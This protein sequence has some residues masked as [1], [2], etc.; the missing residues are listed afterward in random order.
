MKLAEKIGWHLSSAV[1]LL[2]L[3]KIE[4]GRRRGW[5]RMRW[6]NGITDSMDLSLS[7]LAIWR[8]TGRPGVLQSIGSQRVGHDWVTELSWAVG[9]LIATDGSPKIQ[10]TQVRSHR[11]SFKSVWLFLTVCAQSDGLSCWTEEMGKDLSVH[12]QFSFR[13][14]Y[15]SCQLIHLISNLKCLGQCIHERSRNR[16]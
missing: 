3:G 9:L 1:G 15:S 4:G 14:N 2:M 7:K 10:K 13:S 8:W 11:M 16:C 6:L 12:H 5:Q